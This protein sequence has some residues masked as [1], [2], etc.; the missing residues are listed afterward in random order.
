MLNNLFEFRKNNNLSKEEL[1]NNLNI[2]LSF[3]SK[4]ETGRRNP[5]YNFLTKLKKYYPNIVIDE[6]FFNIQSH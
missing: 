2:S 6:I 3:Y 4:I 1:A 5:S